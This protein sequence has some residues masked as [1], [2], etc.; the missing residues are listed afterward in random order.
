MQEVAETHFLK[1][2]FSTVGASSSPEK[3]DQCAKGAN[4]VWSDY[5]WKY[6]SSYM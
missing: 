2:F 4:C 3:C 5:Y 6:T 1:K